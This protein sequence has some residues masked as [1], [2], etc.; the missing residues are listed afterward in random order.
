L[1]A[2][3]RA[4]LYSRGE[5][6]ANSITHGVGII[7]AIGGLAV[8]AT[9]ASLRGNAWHIASCC[10]FGTTLILL[11]AASTLYHAIQNPGSKKILQILDHSAIFLLIAGTYT[12][13]TL[14]NLR[15]PWGWSLFGAIWGLAGLGIVFQVSPLRKRSV[16]S[17]ALYVLMGWAALFATKPMLDSMSLGGLVLLLLGGTAYTAGIGFYAWRKLPYSHAIWHGF[18]L[19]G[20]VLHYFAILFYVIPMGG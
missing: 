5:E 10:I 4:P 7:L 16:L 13:I 2:A 12:P 17:L 14:V 20:S 3:V 9:F 15:G 8:L 1:T 6:I 19:A 11:Y 18:V